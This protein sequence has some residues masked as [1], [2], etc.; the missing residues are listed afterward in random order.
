MMPLSDTLSE[1]AQSLWDA[2]RALALTAPHGGRAL[3]PLLFF[4]DPARTPRP[5]ETAARLPAGAGVVFRHFGAAD[6]VETGQRLREATHRAGVRLLVGLDAELAEQIGADGVH[7]P[8]RALSAAYAL[9]GRRPDWLL[10]GAAHSTKAV[11]TAR[12]LHALVLSPVFPA[13]GASGVKPALGVE[14]FSALAAL[15]PCPVYALGGITAAN[16]SRLPSTGA[17]GLAGVEA[18]QTAFAG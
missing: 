12:D 13:G 14:G 1:E 16:A 11:R 2:A 17:S 15:A 7:L 5:W 9:S 8:E 18:I 3:P 6:R 10:T 4:T